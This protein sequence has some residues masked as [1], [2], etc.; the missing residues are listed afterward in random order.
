MLPLVV[1]RPHEDVEI[2]MDGVPRRF[3][4]T[5]RPRDGSPPMW[6]RGGPMTPVNLLPSVTETNPRGVEFV[7]PQDTRARVGEASCV[8]CL[9]RRRQVACH[10]CGH[11]ALCVTCAVRRA[12]R[13]CPVCDAAA[14]STMVVFR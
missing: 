13:R 10:P 9:T 14:E 3:F 8:L 7:H 12:D 6:V 4:G 2:G 5:Y 1:R 11:T